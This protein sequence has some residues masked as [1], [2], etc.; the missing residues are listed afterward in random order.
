MD[1]GEDGANVHVLEKDT[2]T[3]ASPHSCQPVYRWGPPELWLVFPLL[4]QKYRVEIRRNSSEIV[5]GESSQANLGRNSLYSILAARMVC[6]PFF[7]FQRP[8]G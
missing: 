4:N 1:K 7:G 8:T 6:F 2:N 3:I 5:N